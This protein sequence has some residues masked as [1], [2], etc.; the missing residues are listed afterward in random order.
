[1]ITLGSD[2]TWDLRALVVAAQDSALFMRLDNIALLSRR[3]ASKST[4]WVL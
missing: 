2:V 1:M 4:F 3:S